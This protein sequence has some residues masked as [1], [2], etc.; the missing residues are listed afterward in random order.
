MKL[1]HLLDL[2]KL[3]PTVKAVFCLKGIKKAYSIS[4]TS[5]KQKSIKA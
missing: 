4:G 3:S 2:R 1:W 5:R